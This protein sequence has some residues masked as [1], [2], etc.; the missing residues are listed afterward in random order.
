MSQMAF[1]MEASRTYL[2]AT[3]LAEDAVTLAG[4]LYIDNYAGIASMKITLGCDTPLS[5]EHDGFAE[6][7]FFANCGS[8]T[9]Y[10]QISPNNAN[11]NHTCLW[12]GSQFPYQNGVVAHEG[13]AFLTFDV[14]LPQGTPAGVYHCFTKEGYLLNEAGLKEYYCY[15]YSE[16]EEISI[17]PAALEIIVE[18]DALRGDVDCDGDVDADDATAALRFYTKGLTTTDVTEC[19]EMLNTP[20]IHT[21]MQAAE[22]NGVEGITPDDA[23]LILRYYV[24]SLS[25]AADW[26]LL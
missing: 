7:S 4:A 15:A 16:T 3:E 8:E 17:S 19:Y 22:A 11:Y 12:Y 6:P 25:G 24:R 21:A 26:E 9:R 10:V 2:S 23:I 20:Y 18:P 14:R 13:G 5:I 1:R